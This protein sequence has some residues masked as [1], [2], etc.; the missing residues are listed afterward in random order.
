MIEDIINYIKYDCEICINQK[1]GEKLNVNK[2]ILV[3]IGPK[4]RF[5][6]DGFELDEITKEITGYSHAIEIIEHFSPF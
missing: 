4:E 1:S 2:K 6:I 5:I 3:T